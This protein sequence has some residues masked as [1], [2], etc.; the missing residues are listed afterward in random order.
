MTMELMAARLPQ[1][2]VQSYE[3]DDFL[4]DFMLHASWESHYCIIP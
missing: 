1:P 2:A 4:S 3:E